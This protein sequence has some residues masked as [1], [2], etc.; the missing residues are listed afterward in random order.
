MAVVQLAM[1]YPVGLI[2]AC[3]NVIVRD[4]EYLVAITLQLLFFLTP[5]V[6]EP[7]AIPKEYAWLFD[8]N[9]FSSMISAWRAIFYHGSLD[10]PA[11]GRCLLFAAMAGLLA[12]YVHRTLDPR[13]GE[14]L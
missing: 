6:Y 13:I 10:A 8:L 2:L 9:P 5:I 3:A 4:V 7:A 12:W 14:L 1:L 11:I